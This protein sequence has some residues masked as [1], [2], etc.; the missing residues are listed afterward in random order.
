MQENTATSREWARSN[1]RPPLN[2]YSVISLTT[3][4]PLR[5]RSC[6][7]RRM[8]G[9]TSPRQA[10]AF[11]ARTEAFTL[12][13]LLRFLRRVRRGRSTV[14]HRRPTSRSRGSTDEGLG[15][16][17]SVDSSG[18][19]RLQAQPGGMHNR[20]ARTTDCLHPVGLQLTLNLSKVP[21]FQGTSLE[22]EIVLKT[23]K[24]SKITHFEKP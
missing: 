21:S 12:L 13:L 1:H 4:R 6:R 10:P 14:V 18:G 2:H 17:P 24:N 9:R 11:I 15:P 7:A 22:G 5:T 3:A 20:V 23:E 19:G 16:G 8:S